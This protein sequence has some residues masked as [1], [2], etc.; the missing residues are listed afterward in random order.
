VREREREERR[1]ERR[2]GGRE[3]R[4]RGGAGRGQRE[5]SEVIR[6]VKTCIDIRIYITYMYTHV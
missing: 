2:E 6:L 1:E 4:G 5:R 3:K